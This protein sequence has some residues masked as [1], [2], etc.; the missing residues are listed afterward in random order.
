[1]LVQYSNVGWPV[2]RMQ[3]KQCRGRI[4]VH[5]LVRRAANI[6]VEGI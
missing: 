3:T 4:G 1:M 6:W 5:G 2:A